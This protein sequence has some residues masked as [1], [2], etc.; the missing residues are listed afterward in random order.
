MIALHFRN[1]M[2]NHRD[3][4]V[5]HWNYCVRSP[6]T[7]PSKVLSWKMVRLNKSMTSSIYIRWVTQHQRTRANSSWIYLILFSRFCIEQWIIREIRHDLHFNIDTPF[8]RKQPIVVWC[9]RTWNNCDNDEIASN[10][11]NSSGMAKWQRRTRKW[12]KSQSK[13]KTSFLH[14]YSVT[15][16]G[17]FEIWYPVRVT[18]VQHFYRMAPKMCWLLRWKLFPMFRTILS[19][20]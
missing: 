2:P 5:K 4:F 15:V 10:Q 6:V 11:Q 17:Q 7:M 8:E 12:S 9:G 19:R 1:N 14:L 13:N 18:N 3:W 16:L 20:R